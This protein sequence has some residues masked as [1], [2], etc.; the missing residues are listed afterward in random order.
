M[1]TRIGFFLCC[2]L[3]RFA[4]L[5]CSSSSLHR[6]PLPP[7]HDAIAARRMCAAHAVPPS[8]ACIEPRLAWSFF[9]AFG[10]AVSFVFGFTLRRIHPDRQQGPQKLTS[11]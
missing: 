1:F 2:A 5:A 9:I 11:R 4:S 3:S 6:P 7:A 8:A 10:C